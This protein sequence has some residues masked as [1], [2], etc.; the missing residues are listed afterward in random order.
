MKF[1]LLF[2]MAFTTLNAEVYRK[3]DSIIDT[4]NHLQWINHSDIVTLQSIWRGAQSYCDNSSFLRHSDWELPTPKEMQTLVK[5][6]N[7]HNEVTQGLDA[8]VYWTNKEDPED[9][10]FAYEVYIVN[11][12]TSSADKCDQERFLCV[13]HFSK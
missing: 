7:E 13:R 12:H 2:L 11:G 3:D 9:D 1:F 8:S 5:I 6:Y 4:D 10:L